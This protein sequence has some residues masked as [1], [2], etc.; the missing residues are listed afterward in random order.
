LTGWTLDTLKEHFER[1]FLDMDKAVAAA[2][3]AQKEATT[4]AETA[5]ERRFESVN[6]FRAQLSDQA[7]TFMPRLEA[8]QRIA[9]NA[10]KLSALEGRVN[11]TDGRATGIS[12][13]YAA[14]IA[15]LGILVGIGSLA[16][17]LL[18]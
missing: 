2:L 5:A 16:A 1:R 8:E 10:E 11:K 7:N 12:G 13:L 17:L 18:R 6:E 9:Q 4:K 15:G 14:V 3:Q